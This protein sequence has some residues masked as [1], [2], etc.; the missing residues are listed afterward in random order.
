VL[1]VLAGLTGVGF[2]VFARRAPWRRYPWYLAG[3]VPG[4]GGSELAL[5][6]AAAHLAAGGLAIGL[7]ATRSRLGTAGLLAAAGSVAGLLDLGRSASAAGTVLEQALAESVGPHPVEP[8]TRRSRRPLSVIRDVAY[9]DEAPEQVLDLWRAPD[10]PVDGRAPVLVQVHGGSWIGGSK[11]SQGVHLMRYLAERGW[12][13]VSID[14]RLGPR[15][16]WPAQIVDVKRALAWVR[17]HITEFGGDP[18]F[19]ALTG[20]SAGGQLAA[21]AALSAND[22]AFQPGFEAADTSVVAAALLYGVYDLTALNDDGRPRLRDYVR[23]VIFDTDHDQDP[24]TWRA[25]SPTLR[26]DRT[27]PPMFVVHGDRDE[28]VSV[29]QARAFADRARAV[30]AQPFGYAELPYAHHAF[31]LVAS[32][33]TMATVRAVTRFL[34]AIHARHR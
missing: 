19:L 17:E 20:G 9:H 4:I 26:V 21:V 33:R 18:T 7:G 13:C 27:A 15:N 11:R 24:T 25:A 16:R 34:E 30:S 29:N 6:V 14:Y 23:K 2:N 22:P 5:P 31:D 28:I 8:R 1:A 12:I 3:L 32:T 10:L